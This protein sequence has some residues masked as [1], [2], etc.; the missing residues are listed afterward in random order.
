[1]SAP[2]VSRQ[3]PRS[4]GKLVFFIVFGLLTVFV[5][6]MKNARIFDPTSP[7][8]QHFA[9]AG[10]FLAVHAFFGA[11]AMTLGVFQF[12]NRL[13]ARYL[14]VHRTLGYV[15]VVGVFIAAPFAIPVAIKTGTPSLVAA[16]AAQSLG[17]VMCTAI[18]LYCVRSGNVAQH[19]RWMMRGYPFAMVFTVARL[20][21]P[22]PPIFRMGKTGVEIVVW[23][24]IV[25]AALLP[26][27]LLEWQA[28]A[29]RAVKAVAQGTVR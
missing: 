17:W 27:V 7:I 5:V 29:P 4:Q 8:A 9:P 23:T 16:S 2:A 25:L 18:A 19:R 13:R 28:M 14:K 6:Y 26:N 3:R 11:L 21:I 12:S 15:Y 24:A 10:W 22:I 1:M 20:L